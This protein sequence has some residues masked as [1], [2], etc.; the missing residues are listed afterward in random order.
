MQV[1]IFQKICKFRYT[2]L[3]LSLILLHAEDSIKDEPNQVKDDRPNDDIFK[4]IFI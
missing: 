3:V 2:S 1:N 4:L